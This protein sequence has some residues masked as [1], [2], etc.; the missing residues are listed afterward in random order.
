MSQ[1]LQLIS[2]FNI[3]VLGR[4]LANSPEDPPVEAVTAPFNQVFQTLAS[5][6]DNAA[7]IGLLWTRPEGVIAS[8]EK[9]LRFEGYDR[10]AVLAEVDT[11]ADAVLSYASQR[12][13]VLVVQWVPTTNDR[14]HGMLDWRP[15]IGLRGLMAGMQLR[16][17]EQLSEAA[18]V[19]VVDP[20]RWVSGHRTASADKMWF[21]TKMPFENEAFKKAAADIKGILQGLAGTSRRLIVLDLDDT[22]WGGVV[23]EQGWQAL[24]LGGHDFRGEAYAAFQRELNSLTRRGI[25]LAVVSKNTESIALDAIDN[26]PEMLLRQTDLA[27]WRINWRDKAQNIRELSDELNLG[28]ASMVFIDDD[29]LERARVRDELPEVLV[30]E[31]PKDPAHFVSAL[32]ALNCFEK[33]AFN[34]EDAGRTAMY[35]TERER[36]TSRTQ[37]Q[38]FDDWLLTLEIE[39]AVAG[40]SPETMPRVAQLFNKTNQMNL[41]TRRM[42]Q[43]EISAWA[44]GEERWF[45]TARVR[46]RYGD[47]GLAG[48]VS[49]EQ[50]DD[51]AYL[52]D[53]IL[54]CRVM[55]RRVEETLLALAVEH[56][57]EQ[58]AK[59]LVATYLPT[60]RNAPC[61][62]VFRESQLIE[63]DQ[64]FRWD[65]SKPY[66]RPA[67][68]TVVH[69]G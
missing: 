56:A 42:S 19:Y 21:A 28:L 57:R 17:A 24:R 55:G 9:A 51:V 27:G 5:S 2:D 18:N 6:A 31:W 62:Q 34:K 37:H 29:P 12:K 20:E 60:E 54:S 50:I 4:L 45:V 39:V 40:L 48:I 44:E 64:V 26:N 13:F 43:E 49:V 25:Q 32:H 36:R 58:G 16:L 23:G 35:V 1:S 15:R 65:C 3:E 41:S 61:L 46:D 67:C 59:Q 7:T 11:F 38:S 53:L 30:P 52:R 10:D 63:E 68:T 47:S 69:L 8:Y 66:P 33:S 14:G 22:L